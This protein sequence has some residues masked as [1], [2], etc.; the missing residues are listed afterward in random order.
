MRVTLR[1]FSRALGTACL[2]VVCSLAGRSDAQVFAVGGVVTAVNDTGSAAVTTGFHTWG[3]HVFG[4]MTLEGHVAL[5]L[6]GSRFTVSGSGTGAP[7]IRVNAATVSAMYLFNEDW[8]HAGL[9]GGFGG[10]F[11]RPVTPG[12]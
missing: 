3:G 8:F 4:E 9:F 10:Y 1:T 12:P 6:R 2:L 7:N 5:Q 11:L